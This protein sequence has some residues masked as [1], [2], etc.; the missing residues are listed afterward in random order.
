MAMAVPAKRMK[1]KRVPLPPHISVVDKPS[2]QKTEITPLQLLVARTYARGMS[3]PDIAHRYAHAIVPHEPNR[4]RQLK[5]CRQRIRKWFSTEK[6]RNII[7]SEAQVLLDLESPA[8]LR[9]VARKARAGR[10]DAARL[11]LELNGRHSPHTDIT[12]AKVNIVFG[13]IPRPHDVRMELEDPNVVDVDPDAE[14]EDD[15]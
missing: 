6:M 15:E 9:G 2:N 11:A 1:R 12:P 8:I 14:I 13:G 7:W 10:V 5:K 4:D 3:I